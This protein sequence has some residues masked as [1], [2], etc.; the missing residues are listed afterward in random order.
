MEILNISKIFKKNVGVKNVTLKINKG[1]L[2]GLIGPNGAGKTTLMKL[3][4]G[5]I[6]PDKGVIK[7]QDDELLSYFPDS[8]N[9]PLNMKANEYIEYIGFLNSLSKKDVEE[10]KEKL[11]KIF[12][13]KVYENKYLKDL[14]AGLKKTLIL[15]GTLIIKPNILFLDEPTA[16]L[17]LESKINFL[18]VIRKLIDFNITIIFTTHLFEEI[19][20]LINRV[21]LISD[22][23]IKLDKKIDNNTNIEELYKSITNKK[24]VDLEEFGEFWGN[25]K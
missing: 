18:N 16:N 14:S 1:D 20:G 19:K 15:I 10:S 24:T 23:I 8:N 25:K 13:F 22:G 17:D 4:F 7:L 3:I 6:I 11:Y 9:I 12:D 21:V 2:I 5:E